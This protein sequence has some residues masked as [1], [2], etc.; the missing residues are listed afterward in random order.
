VFLFLVFTA[1]ATYAQTVDKTAIL[2]DFFKDKGIGVISKWAHPMST[3]YSSKAEIKVNG[4]VI[5]LSL[6]YIKEAKKFTCTYKVI[7]NTKSYFSRL[8]FEDAYPQSKCFSA[9]ESDKNLDS[10]LKMYK[11]DS[12]VV[13]AVEEILH[14]PVKDF[15]CNDKCLLGLNYFWKTNGSR[16]K[17]LGEAPQ[18]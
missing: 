1:G 2:T 8:T 13:A 11:G 15:D 14:R 12:E 17:Y 4:S 10:F 7:I 5:D 6:P 9:C 18:K 16:A 3:C